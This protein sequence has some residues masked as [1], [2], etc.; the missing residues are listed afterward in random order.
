LLQFLCN[1]IVFLDWNMKKRDGDIAS[2]FQKIVAKKNSSSSSI[3]SN[4][5][6]GHD[7]DIGPSVRTTNDS[8]ISGDIVPSVNLIIDS[9]TS[10]E[11]MGSSGTPT[12]S[13]M[14]PLPSPIYDPGRLPQDPTERLSI[15]SYSINDQ[16]L[17][18]L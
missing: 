18:L 12:P 9:R 15:V 8:R 17:F 4:D 3:P 16:D 6:M 10:E 5:A 2:L 1:L 11:N 14:P 13:T 7:G